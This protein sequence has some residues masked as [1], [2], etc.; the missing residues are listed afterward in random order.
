MLGDFLRRGQTLSCTTYFGC[1]LTMDGAISYLPTVLV[2]CKIRIRM[3][4]TCPRANS[5]SLY[6]HVRLTSQVQIA[7]ALHPARHTRGRL[8]FT[9][10]FHVKLDCAIANSHSLC[11]PVRPSCASA[12]TLFICRCGSRAE[13]RMAPD[14]HLWYICT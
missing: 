2:E 11:L 9:D 12:N 13:A 10:C 1:T 6:L 8:V 3:K 7:T 5:C 14:A 4:L